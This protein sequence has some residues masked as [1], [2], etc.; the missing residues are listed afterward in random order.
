MNQS[1]KLLPTLFSFIA[2]S[3]QKNANDIAQLTAPTKANKEMQRQLI[4]GA[5]H[6]LRTANEAF[7]C[8]NSEL[9]GLG[10]QIGQINSRV[11]SAKLSVTVL[12]Q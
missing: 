9:L 11:F 6:V 5:Y 12:V 3:I 2:T 8:G 7:Y 4:C 1:L 10:R